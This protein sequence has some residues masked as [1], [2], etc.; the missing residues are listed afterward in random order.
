MRISLYI[1][2]IWFGQRGG[3]IFPV[4]FHFS[5]HFSSQ[6]MRWFPTAKYNVPKALREW[7]HL[8]V[9]VSNTR[10]TYSC[11]IY[12]LWPFTHIHFY[13]SIQNCN[14]LSEGLTFMLTITICHIPKYFISWKT[15]K[16]E[17]SGR[18]NE[19]YCIRVHLLYLTHR[20]ARIICRCCFMFHYC[21]L[22][23]W[24]K[25]TVK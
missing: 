19:G 25:R 2:G 23:V 16:W 17:S 21:C 11:Q 8:I 15:F 3:L 9:K 12:F 10:C 1:S 22:E 13:T 7:I 18:L 14:N 5:S 4:I 24:L 6:L 20:V